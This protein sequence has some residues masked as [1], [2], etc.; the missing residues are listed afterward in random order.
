MAKILGFI[1]AGISLYIITTAVIWGISLPKF[2]MWKFVVMLCPFIVFIIYLLYHNNP[3]DRLLVFII[4]LLPAMGILIPPR[5]LGLSLFD[6]LVLLGIILIF[7]KALISTIDISQ[8]PLSVLIVPIVFIFPSIFLS[9]NIPN[10]VAT[11]MGIVPFYLFFIGLSS[12][13]TIPEWTRKIHYMLMAG[14]FLAA[15]AVIA[16]RAFGVNLSGSSM[17]LNALS[18]DSYLAVR[19]AGGFFQDPQKAGQ[20]LACFIAYFSILW[21]RRFF[22]ERIVNVLLLSILLLSSVALLLTVSR[23]AIL[24]CFAVTFLGVILFNRFGYPARIALAS[25]LAIV[26]AISLYVPSSTLVDTL[27][28]KT[29]SARFSSVDEGT[30]ER[31]M[32]WRGSW[33]LFHTSFLAGVGIGNYQEELIRKGAYLRNSS[34]DPGYIPTQPENGY[35]K[36]LYETGVLGIIGLLYLLAL[37]VKYAL[38]GIRMQS[39]RTEAIAASLAVLVFLATFSTLFTVSNDS[40]AL[41]PVLMLALVCSLRSRAST[42]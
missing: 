33:H 12:F 42:M 24:S 20:F 5:R 32:I 11:F 39:S 30:A 18:E 22:K 21:S 27:L 6:G 23:N 14:L 29:V 7:V 28:P 13:L 10:S 38:K 3:L 16:E 1:L 35:L 9:I 19:R 26:I 8:M 2:E 40:N 36:I 34:G 17:N 41:I 37:F 31:L 15:V 25:L 4:L